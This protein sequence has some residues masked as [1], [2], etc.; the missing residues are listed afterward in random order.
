MAEEENN[1]PEAPETEP[2]KNNAVAE[3]AS[4]AEVAKH[5]KED[6]CWVIIDGEV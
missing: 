5:N 4:A 2:E 6:D 1:T 3:E